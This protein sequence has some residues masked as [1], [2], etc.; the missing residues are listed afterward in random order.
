MTVR[1]A[2]TDGTVKDFP[3]CDDLKAADAYPCFVIEHSGHL[4]MLP[5]V[6]VK[7]IGFKED[8]R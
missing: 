5:F 3:G 8:V 7:Y 1:V 2:F 4:I 6:N